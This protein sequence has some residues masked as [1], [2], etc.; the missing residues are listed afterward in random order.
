M[1]AATVDWKLA[2]F[3]SAFSMSGMMKYCPVSAVGQFL[4]FSGEIWEFAA[5]VAKPAMNGL[6]LYLPPVSREVYGGKNP[7]RFANVVAF[8]SLSM[9]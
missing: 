2:P 8:D 1:A 9:T 4:A 7:C 6:D 3:I 5:A